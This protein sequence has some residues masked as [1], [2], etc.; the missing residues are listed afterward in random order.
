[1]SGDGSASEVRASDGIPFVRQRWF[2]EERAATTTPEARASAVAQGA[3]SDQ[4]LMWW[5]YEARVA[6]S[7]GHAR[8]ASPAAVATRGMC[9]SG[10]V[11]DRASCGLRWPAVRMAIQASFGD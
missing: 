3:T 1:M 8:R 7:S 5:R 11:D 10:S 6:P 9:V 2:P 4:R